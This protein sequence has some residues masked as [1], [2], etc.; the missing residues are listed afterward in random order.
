[1]ARLKINK[2][3]WSF[4]VGALVFTCVITVAFFSHLYFNGVEWDLFLSSDALYL[5]SLYQD[6][7]IDKNSVADWHLNPAPNFFPD[8]A[9][10]FILRFVCGN[11]IWSTFVFALLQV[12]AL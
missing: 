6:I 2:P 4:I 12:L 11:F 1:M 7:L 8:M 10:Y 3:A 9:A 5:P